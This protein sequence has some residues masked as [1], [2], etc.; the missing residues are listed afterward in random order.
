VV[1]EAPG[2]TA[3]SR[4]EGVTARVRLRV[5]VRDDGAVGEVTVAVSSGRSDLDAAA[6]AAAWGWRFQPA[7]RDGVAAASVV[8][9]WV[10]FVSH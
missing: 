2:L 9:I 4:P 6:S 8:L 10:T 7:R 3:D 1:V 5:L